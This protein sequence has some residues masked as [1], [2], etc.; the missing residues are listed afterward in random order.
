MRTT[1]AISLVLAFAATSVMA[2]GGMASSCLSTVDPKG[3]L[4]GVAVTALASERSVESRVDGYATLLSSLARAGVQH[5]GALVAAIDDTDAPIYSRWSLAV[6]RRA[7]ALRFEKNIDGTDE[8][9]RIESLADLLRKRR[10]GLERLTLIWWAC[11]AR[12]DAPKAV[13]AKWDGVLDRLC[14]LDAHDAK[15]LDRELPDL[16]IMAAPLVD[17]FNRDEQALRRSIVTSAAV[18]TGYEARLSQKMSFKAREG[19]QGLL[20]IGHLLNAV[21]LATSGHHEW[22]V[23]EAELSFAYLG[24]TKFFAKAPEF[25]FVTSL[26]AWIYAKA[27]LRS[28]AIKALHD[29]LARVDGLRNASGG[30]R[31]PVYAVAIETLRLLE[32]EQ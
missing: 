31:A 3:C 14:K 1:T 20:V 18:L 29:S 30:A 27:G 12:E 5:D 11:E 8:P 23:R 21:A 16:S 9:S 7:Y 13:L 19:V 17:A 28:K 4:A 26:V 6:S 25:Q 24:R 22:S 2:K 15:A 32:R 10:D